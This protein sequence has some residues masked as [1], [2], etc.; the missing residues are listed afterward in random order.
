MGRILELIMASPNAPKSEGDEEV[1]VDIDALD[2]DTLWKIQA[3]V[4]TI[5]AE[6]AA[7][8]PPRPDAQ[9]AVTATGETPTVDSNHER[10]G[11]AH[12]EGVGSGSEG[13]GAKA[14]DLTTFDAKGWA[15]LSK[16]AGKDTEKP[17]GEENDTL[18]T[19]FKGKEEEQKLLTE[20]RKALEEEEE[21]KKKEAA[22]LAEEEAARKA[23]EEK[24]RA[25]EQAAEAKKKRKKCEGKKQKSSR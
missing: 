20:Q 7:K 17:A 11:E 9:Q 15:D 10:T 23:E 4:D 14:H 21:R 16:E 6:A 5:I 8:Q 3:Y 1:E 18:W 2:D 13:G 25:E 22:R 24:R 19:E 12:G